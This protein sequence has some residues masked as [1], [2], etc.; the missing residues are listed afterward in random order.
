MA[1]FNEIVIDLPEKWCSKRDGCEEVPTVADPAENSN[2]EDVIT[3]LIATKFQLGLEGVVC[4]KV[5]AFDSRKRRKGVSLC[6]TETLEND[7]RLGKLAS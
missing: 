1:A 6:W 7:A 5:T 2:L 4:L 3:R